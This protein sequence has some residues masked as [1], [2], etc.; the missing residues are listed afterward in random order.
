MKKP[1]KKITPKITLEQNFPLLHQ[2][3][4]LAEDGLLIFDLLK[5]RPLS[6][7]IYFQFK[8]MLKAREIEFSCR[9]LNNQLRIYTHRHQYL[10][11]AAKSEKRV[12]IKGQLVA[13]T[14]EDMEKTKI[15]LKNYRLKTNK[16]QKSANAKTKKPE[17]NKETS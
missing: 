4:T 3:N 9:N 1:K 2:V 15:N 5:P 10:K 8:E 17:N 13:M 11:S 12:N 7:G 16:P 14:V 6:I